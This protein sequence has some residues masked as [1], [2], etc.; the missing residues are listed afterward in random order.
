MKYILTLC[1]ALAAFYSSIAQTDTLNLDFEIPA[2][3]AQPAGW[4]IVNNRTPAQP[5]EE[6][7]ATHHLDSSSVQNGRYSYLV[8]LSG[9]E[10]EWSGCVNSVQQVFDAKYVT[11]SGYLKTEIEDGWAGL[12]LRLDGQAGESIEFDNMAAKPVKGVTGW[13]QYSIRLAYD[14]ERARRIVFGALLNGR[15]KLWVDN[16]SIQFDGKKD[17]TTAKIIQPE[18]LPADSDTDHYQGSSF[19]TITVSSTVKRL[20]NLG[21]IWG[22]IKYH[23]PAVREGKHNMDAELFRILGWVLTADDDSS[24]YKLIE[25]WV[26]KFGQPQQCK[27]C[28]KIRDKDE[29]KLMPDYGYLFDENN[30]PASLRRKLEYIRD[31]LEETDE[32]YYI[33]LNQYVD[34]ASFLHEYAYRD[35][36]YPDAGIRLLALYRY[37]NMVQYFF[38]DR[39]LTDTR[40]NEVLGLSIPD[41]CH[42]ADSAEYALACLKLIVRLDDTHAGMGGDAGTIIS[43]MIGDKSPPFICK[44]VEDQVVITQLFDDVYTDV[45][46]QLQRGDII[47]KIDGTDTKNLIEKYLPLVNGSNFPVKMRNM[48]NP[49]RSWLLNSHDRNMELTIKRDDVVKNVSISRFVLNDSLAKRFYNGYDFKDACKLLDGNIGYIHIRNFTDEL[50]DSVMEVLKGTKGIV[51]DMRGYPNSSMAY[52]HVNRFKGKKSPFVKITTPDIS[53][54]GLF[55]VTGTLST[56]GNSKN[57]YGGKLVIIVN[58]ITQSAA[59][60]A[61]M[62]LQTTDGAVV[63][64]CT[65][66]GADGNIVRLTLPGGV[67][68]IFSGIG[69][70]YPDGGESQRVGVRIDKVVEPTIQGVKECR[71]EQLEAAVKIIN[72]G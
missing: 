60:F 32:H 58:E 21:M 35:M 2:Q 54:P 5:A 16:L 19:H 22:F 30:L 48:L 68:T 37:W 61:T 13:Q 7:A 44:Y 57:V 41:F 65:T 23:H 52:G 59:E 4:G 14:P 56:G 46:S 28:V 20:A 49:Y 29:V 9:G 71:D 11:L 55:K 27:K 39:H 70:L 66:S 3:H 53:I 6:Y 63:V 34:N 25:N 40:W 51:L 17:I 45:C 12:W 47:I 26:D 8:N 72:G 1:I 43:E 38:P 67:T 10:K 69:C 31:N 33:A 62:S 64:G 18:I 15:G 42:A 36:A 24:A 50:A